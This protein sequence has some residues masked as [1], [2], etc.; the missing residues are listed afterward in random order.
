LISSKLLSV[1]KV[2]IFLTDDAH[3]ELLDRYLEKEDELRKFVFDIIKELA[4]AAKMTKLQKT[5]VYN[6]EEEDPNIPQRT[7]KKQETMPLK[8]VKLDKYAIKQDADWIPENL[9]KDEADPYVYKVG[10]RTWEYL[11]VFCKMYMAR[12][13]LYNKSI[14]KDD[15]NRKTKL[16]PLPECVEQIFHE[17]LIQ[18]LFGKVTEAAG[19]EFEEEDEKLNEETKKKK[20]PPPKAQQRDHKSKKK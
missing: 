12:L 7:V 17:S 10:D 20:T 8:E 1:H 3:A 6:I 4:V 18:K 14:K 9:E 19:E 11:M 2:K 13:S 16:I 5:F 15:K